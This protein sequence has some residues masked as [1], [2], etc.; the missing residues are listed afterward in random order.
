M[1]N[2]ECD[3]NGSRAAEKADKPYKS[4]QKHCRAEMLSNL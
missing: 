1:I 2:P 3:K 4:M